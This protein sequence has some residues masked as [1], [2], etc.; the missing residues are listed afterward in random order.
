[1]NEGH[2]V[3]NLA[4]REKGLLGSGELERSASKERRF[5]FKQAALVFGEEVTYKGMKQEKCHPFYSPN[6]EQND[7][8]NVLL[9]ENPLG[10]KLTKPTATAYSGSGICRY[11]WQTNQ[12]IDDRYE[13]NHN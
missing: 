4:M 7:S 9:R 3:R 13:R 5:L 10:K 6:H 8:S 12:L 1:V 11:R 2:C